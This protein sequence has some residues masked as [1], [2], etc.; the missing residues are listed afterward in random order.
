MLISNGYRTNTGKN[1]VMGRNM[2]VA[3]HRMTETD[4]LLTQRSH[5]TS[6]DEPP[7][8]SEIYFKK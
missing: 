2:T 4:V 1:S 5:D 3:N 8:F 6:N 7:I